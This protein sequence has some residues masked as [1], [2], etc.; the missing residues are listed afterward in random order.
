ML[1]LLQQLVAR[2]L[3][4]YIV[5]KREPVETDNCESVRYMLRPPPHG[6]GGY[7]R[8]YNHVEGRFGF[9]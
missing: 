4:A 7:I 2:D 6:S 9:E 5:S 3:G 1:L 8:R